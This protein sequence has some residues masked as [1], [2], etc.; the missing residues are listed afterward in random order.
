MYKH[1]LYLKLEKCKFEKE[2]VEYLELVLSNRK[3]EMDA[4]KVEGQ[5]ANPNNKE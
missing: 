1:Y 3:V 5:M 2:R 4:A